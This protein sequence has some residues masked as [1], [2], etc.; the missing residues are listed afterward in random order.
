MDKVKL[1]CPCCRGHVCKT[2]GKAE[3]NKVNIIKRYRDF[4]LPSFSALLMLVAQ[5]GGE[6]STKRILLRDDIPALEITFKDHTCDDD[7]CPWK[8]NDYD[9]IV[10]HWLKNLQRELYDP[11]EA[12]DRAIDYLRRKG[13]PWRVVTGTICNKPCVTKSMID[14]TGGYESEVDTPKK[15]TTEL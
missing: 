10:T 11:Y 9:V 2:V 6:V 1:T 14:L 3:A 13:K 7:G 5:A 12:R 4:R 15:T 8:S